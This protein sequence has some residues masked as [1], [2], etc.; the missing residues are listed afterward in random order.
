M[1][2]QFIRVVVVCVLTFQP[3]M[4]SDQD[5]G[6]LSKGLLA[7]VGNLTR[8]NFSYFDTE[9]FQSHKLSGTLV[10]AK[11]ALLSHLEQVIAGSSQDNSRVAYVL[12]KDDWT[13]A[14]QTI[15]DDL[16]ASRVCSVYATYR[17]D[18]LVDH[19]ALCT[20]A[21]NT[22]VFNLDTLLW[23]GHGVTVLKQVLEDEEFFGCLAACVGLACDKD[24]DMTKL[25]SHG[26]TFTHTFCMAPVFSKLTRLNVYKAVTREGG[27]LDQ[28]LRVLRHPMMP[29]RWQ[30]T[31]PEDKAREYS[32][33][34]LAPMILAMRTVEY[35]LIHESSLYVGSETMPVE[36][37]ITSLVF[38]GY[39]H[40]RLKPLPIHL[41]EY[42]DPNQ[43]GNL[44]EDDDDDEEEEE[45][46]DDDDDD[47]D[48]Q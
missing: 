17:S 28:K 2:V 21:L 8:T 19:V 47:D 46:D 12:C 36:V 10:G 37:V 31:T 15:V 45:E 41:G 39:F 48:E 20:F 35:V 24:V 43:L 29:H 27:F 3:E 38:I 18:G 42:D 34:A 7:A 5:G 6:Q 30:P 40:P 13:R 14:R 23:A 16:T 4:S 1:S 32:S 44:D 25:G 11:S 33:G 9:A 26:V 22:V